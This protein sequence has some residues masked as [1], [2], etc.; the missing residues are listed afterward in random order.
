MA[1]RNV[2]AT[3]TPT[4][5]VAG[6]GLTVGTRY[7]IQNVDPA[8]TVYVREA[9]VAPTGGALRGFVLAPFVHATLV[10]DT[11]VGI[12]LWTGR[13]DGAKLVIDESP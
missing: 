6:L 4:N 5:I 11:G 3:T 13:A 7:T 1:A 10:P 8:A 12:W 9:A 2:D